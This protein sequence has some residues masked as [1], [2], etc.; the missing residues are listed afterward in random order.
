MEP[1]V[2]GRG[3]FEVGSHTKRGLKAGTGCRVELEDL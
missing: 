1:K 2:M 3:T